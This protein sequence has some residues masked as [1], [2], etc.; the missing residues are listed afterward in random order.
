MPNFACFDD[1]ASWAVATEGIMSRL[2]NRKVEPTTAGFMKTLPKYKNLDELIATIAEGDRNRETNGIVEGFNVYIRTYSKT[3]LE[4]TP[5]HVRAIKTV[6]SS[7]GAA[8]K[9]L[10]QKIIEEYNST[11]GV[12]GPWAWNNVPNFVFKPMSVT[13]VTSK[14]KLETLAITVAN[15]QYTDGVEADFYFDDGDLWSG[16]VL[17]LHDCVDPKTGKLTPNNPKTSF[18]VAG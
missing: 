7:I 1:V 12:R 5:Q 14:I 3:G 17:I 4:L 18:E 15:D 9:L 2:R 6:F 13:D 16:H 10:A 8:Q 11:N